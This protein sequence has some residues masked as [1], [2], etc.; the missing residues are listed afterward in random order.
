[1]C[2]SLA[3][4]Q[5]VLIFL[6]VIGAVVQILKLLIPFALK[7]MGAEIGEGANLVMSVL[8]II[9]MAV[10]AIICVVICIELISCMLSYTGGL[11]LSPRR[12]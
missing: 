4:L 12:G 5:Q 9:F 11:S 3:W 10:V 7:R 2:F 8:H 1:M 6:I